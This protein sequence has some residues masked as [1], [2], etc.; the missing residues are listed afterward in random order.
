MDKFLIKRPRNSVD[1]SKNSCSTP[2]STST[3]TPTST[4][5]TPNPTHSPVANPTDEVVSDPGLRKQIIEFDIG[6]RDRI[7]REYISKGACQPKVHNF[8][9]TQF[10]NSTRSFREAW[11]KKYDWLEYSISKDAAYCFICFLFKPINV[12]HFGDEAY[13]RIGFRNWKR[14]IE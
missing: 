1:S 8:P 4:P 6:S 10:G 14:A 11:Y 13:T 3:P 9:R 12:I 2:A 5:A 7:R